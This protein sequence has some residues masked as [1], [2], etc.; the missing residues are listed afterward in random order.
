[1]SGSEEHYDHHEDHHS[2]E[3]DPEVYDLKDLCQLIGN[4]KKIVDLLL[5]TGVFKQARCSSKTCRRNMNIVAKA[6]LGDGCH[7]VCPVCKR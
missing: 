4:Q 1:M 7:W 6:S 3:E 5:E 2:D